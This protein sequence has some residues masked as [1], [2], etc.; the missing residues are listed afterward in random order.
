MLTVNQAMQS[1][2]LWG[3]N[4]FGEK[5]VR[6]LCDALIRNKTLTELRLQTNR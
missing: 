3:D 2:S 4:A 5:G 1:L 6:A